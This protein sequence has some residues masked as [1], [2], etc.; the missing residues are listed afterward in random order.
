M[1]NDEKNNL[2]YGYAKLLKYITITADTIKQTAIDNRML[3]RIRQ[4]S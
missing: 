3:W 4:R 2:T 1:T